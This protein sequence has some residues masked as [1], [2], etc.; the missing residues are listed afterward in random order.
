MKEARVLRSADGDEG[1]CGRRTGGGEELEC[2]VLLAVT[3]VLRLR[4]F[5][6][7]LQRELVGRVQVGATL[8]VHDTELVL[9]ELV[10]P[11]RLM[12]AHVAL[13]L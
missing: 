13:L 9:G 6:E 10:E 2:R 11:A 8:D 5:G 3:P 12:M 1:G 7:A 4:A